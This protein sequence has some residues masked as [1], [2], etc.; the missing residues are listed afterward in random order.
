MIRCMYISGVP[1]TGKR[2][3]VYEVKRK[4]ESINKYRPFKFIEIN[5]L[6]LS[7]PFQSYVQILF[8]SVFLISILSSIDNKYLNNI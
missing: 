7:D 4:L 1:G 5:G 6:R 3:T 2:A 8:V